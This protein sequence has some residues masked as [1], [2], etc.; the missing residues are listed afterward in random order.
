MI[1][2]FFLFSVLCF[3]LFFLLFCVVPLSHFF[4]R[5]GCQKRASFSP[6][7]LKKKKADQRGY[8]IDFD[9]DLRRVT[10]RV[11]EIWRSHFAVEARALPP[12]DLRLPLFRSKF[13]RQIR[14][15]STRKTSDTIHNGIGVKTKPDDV[16]SFIHFD[17]SG[18]GGE[19]AAYRRSYTKPYKPG[20]GLTCDG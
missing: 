12:A 20:T 6:K 4:S 19:D 3:V 13:L 16:C 1:F 5:V 18:N 11:S 2:D 8:T 9:K 17:N 15:C 14:L 7:V 10:V